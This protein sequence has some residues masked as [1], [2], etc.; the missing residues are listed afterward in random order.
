MR[1][2]GR[3]T[4]EQYSQVPAA[5]FLYV[6]ELLVKLTV[7]VIGFA[8][9]EFRSSEAHNISNCYDFMSHSASRSSPFMVWSLGW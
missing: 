9:V 6:D 5:T 4:L 2:L 8:D 3:A 7:L 1:A